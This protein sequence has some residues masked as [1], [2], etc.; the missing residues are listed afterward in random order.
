[1]VA[2]RAAMFAV[3]F[4]LALAIASGMME[5][6]DDSSLRTQWRCYRMSAWGDVCVYDNICFDG[7]HFTFLDRRSLN[8]NA[9]SA[10]TEFGVKDMQEGT[11][12]PTR[13]VESVATERFPFNSGVPAPCGSCRLLLSQWFPTCVWTDEGAR[14]SVVH[15]DALKSSD[16]TFTWSSRVFWRPALDAR[17]SN[18]WYFGTRV[19]PLFKARQM[20]NTGLFATSLPSMDESDILFVTLPDGESRYRN[21]SWHQTVLQVSTG[22]RV[23]I[24]YRTDPW[25]QQWSPS[26]QVCFKQAVLTGAFA[27]V[28]RA[29]FS[30]VYKSL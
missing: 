21:S 29:W 1:M 12:V 2:T 15:P 18:I 11:L 8:M 23:P 27:Y 9:S 20:N 25:A 17:L 28:V 4:K 14:S 5:A 30:Q 22:G 10:M 6:G 19:L 7:V 13:R 24:M 16:T 3:L 26:N